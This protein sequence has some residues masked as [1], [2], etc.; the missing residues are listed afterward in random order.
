VITTIGYG[1]STPQTVMGKI[2]CMCY[3]LIGIPLCLVMFQSVGERLNYF[4]SFCIKVVKK[5]VRAHNVEV[6]QTEMVCVAGLFALFVTTGGAAMFSHYEGWS[7]FNSIY[8]CVI[9]LT[10]IGFGDYVV[11]ILLDF[12]ICDSI[13]K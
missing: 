11:C 8:Y 1:H 7:Y 6:S 10:T 5:C 2:F 3:A 4:G 13:S 9:T 12:N